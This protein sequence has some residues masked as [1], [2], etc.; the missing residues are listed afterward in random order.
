V[1]V[2][3][4]LF[5]VADAAA[6][7]RTR[8]RDESLQKPLA[9]LRHSC[10]EA[11]RAW[12][13][14]N[15]GYHATVYFEGLKPKPPAAQF[16]PEF[17]MMDRWPTHQPHPGWWIWDHQSVI[18]R[19]LAYAG[20]ADIEAIEATLKKLREE[21]SD[22]K[23]RAISL[24]TAV[25]SK[26]TFLDRKLKQIEPLQI[27][28]ARTIAFSFL[29][30]REYWSR[31][32][33]AMSQGCRI[34]P[35]QSLIAIPLS[36]TAVEDGLA[37]LEKA[38]RESALHLERIAQRKREMT[39]TGKTVFIGH[40]GSAMWLQLE[41][42]L[43][44]RLHLPVDEFNSVPPAGVPTAIRLEELLDRAAFAFLV[45]TAE[46]EQSDG[47][48]RARENVVHEAGLFQGRLGFRKAIILIEDICKE[49][50]NIHGLG[51]I[52]FAKGKIDAEFEK[53]RQVLEREGLIAA[54]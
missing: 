11:E 32:S 4:E 42:F 5:Q 30:K 52:R 29:P 49:F 25:Q 38:T 28:D 46:D 26:D 54:S 17:G 53:V 48:F 1:T 33:L 36:A 39:A 3:D 51:Q 19:I 50:S 41:K 43:K 13:G 45:M 23:E 27:A 7:A 9:A 31:D 15:I 40:G 8:I 21:F 12:S 2:K 10:D 34:A 6:D 18:D 24:F 37:I 14:S 22:L 16:S 35:H 44:D 20:G 47:T